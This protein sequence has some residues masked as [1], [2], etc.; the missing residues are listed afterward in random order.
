MEEKRPSPL[1]K[2]FRQ[3]DNVGMASLFA[4]LIS[5]ALTLLACYF[6]PWLYFD[7]AYWVIPVVVVVVWV[8]G[9]VANGYRH[10]AIRA[11]RGR[12]VM[13]PL[14]EMGLTSF[15]WSMPTLPFHKKPESI[16]MRD[17]TT[18][19]WP[20]PFSDGS[21]TIYVN[22]YK[23][24]LYNWLVDCYTRQAWLTGKQSA[25]SRRLN[26]KLDYQQWQARIELLK[27]GGAIYRNSTA[28]NATLYLR[29]IEGMGVAEMAWYIVDGLL[30]DVE[31]SRKI[32]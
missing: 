31:G 5:L 16:P 8:L 28:S 22:V 21:E 12:S 20:V 19:G 29:V 4:S 23:M 11:A 18:R 24:E 1:N 30:E 10:K 15:G 27:N 7:G 32:W 3:L 17:E 25:I 6:Y 2:Y 13:R 9:P 26:R 14:T